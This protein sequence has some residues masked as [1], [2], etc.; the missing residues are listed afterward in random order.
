MSIS[1]DPRQLDRLAQ[2]ETTLELLK[3]PETYTALLAD[4]KNTI[5]LM[6][7]ASKKHS[8]AEAAD[9]FLQEAKKL[10]EAAKKEAA[11]IKAEA[12]AMKAA[13]EVE[14]ANLAASIVVHRTT[15]DRELA[16]LE[17]R[18][19]SLA[20]LEAELKTRLDAAAQQEAR[21]AEA[22]TKLTLEQSALAAAKSEFNAKLAALKA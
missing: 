8:T 21:I 18:K 7:D 2:L 1:V 6:N 9:R 22:L 12:S 4:V 10:L 20:A 19:G 3:N 13:Q 15:A 17:A 5:R 16:D 11:Q 14:Q